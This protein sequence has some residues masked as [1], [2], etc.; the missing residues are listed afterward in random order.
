MEKSSVTKEL[1]ADSFHE[2]MLHREFDK[3]TIKHITDQA[4]VIRPTFYYHFQDKYD[5]LEYILVRDVVQPALL[6]IKEIGFDYEG[7]RGMMAAIEA[8]QLFYQKAFRVTGQ[9]GFYEILFTNFRR[10][11]LEGLAESSRTVPVSR[12]MA[13]MYYANGLANVIRFWIESGKK[14]M[15]VDEICRNYEYLVT[16]SVFDV[17]H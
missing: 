12:E 11:I 13:A 5:V 3:I 16:H 8:D 2:L 9:N 15:S 17:L 7:V 6:R 14:A 10:A 1:L 4:G